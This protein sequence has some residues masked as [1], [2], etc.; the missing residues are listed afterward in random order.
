M[1]LEALERATREKYRAVFHLASPAKS[2]RVRHPALGDVS[3]QR[4]GNDDAHRFCAERSGAM[5]LFASTSEAYGRSARPPAAGNVFRQR[6]S[7]WTARVLRRRQAVRR[8][9]DVGRH[10][11][12]RSRRPHRFAFSTAT[13]RALDIEDGRL[14]PSLMAAA[15]DRRPLPVHGDGK[16]NAI[17]DVRRRFG[18][19]FCYAS[20]SAAMSAPCRSIL[21]R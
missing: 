19:R 14:V 7:G 10:P 4:R 1:V 21:A 8:S 5:M 11:G 12:T 16:Q 2:R 20:P 3:R 9:R 15:R 13:G 17:V 6:E 18:R